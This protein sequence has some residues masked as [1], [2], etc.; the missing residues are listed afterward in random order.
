MN[1]KYC[2]DIICPYCETKLDNPW[3]LELDLN[4]DEDSTEVECEC[5]ETYIVSVNIR[6]SYNTTKL[7]CSEISEKCNFVLS[8]DITPNP[9]EYKG[10]NYTLWMCT[11]C[12]KKVLKWGPIKDEPYIIDPESND[13]DI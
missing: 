11:K 13:Y 12:E 1:T 4:H 7:E 6:V 10:K 9:Y 3:E 2:D 8:T 5:G